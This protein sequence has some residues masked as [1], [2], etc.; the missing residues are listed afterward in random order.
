MEMDK[1]VFDPLYVHDKAS[2]ITKAPKVMETPRLGIG[3]LA[4]TVNHAASS[5]T[6]IDEVSTILAK[7]RKVVTT[8]KK[9]DLAN[10]TFKKSKTS[11]CQASSTS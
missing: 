5:A 10:R 6:G 4:H 7:G 2:H 9:S 3:C 11:F 1:L 8:F